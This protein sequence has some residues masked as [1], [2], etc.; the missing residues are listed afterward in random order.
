MTIKQQLIK[1]AKARLSGEEVACEK[2][3]WACLRFLDD[4]EKEK[5]KNTLSEPFLYHW[6]EIE[7]QKI[8]DWFALLKHHKGALAGEF[9]NL[10]IDQKFYVC[11]LYGWREDTNGYKRFTHSF[12]E[13]ARK[14]AKSQ[15][16]AGIA[17][18]EISVEATK[19]GEIYEAYTAGTK[20]EQS[21]I[22]FDEANNMLKGSPLRK[23]FNI[24]RN[25]ITHK[26]TGSYIKTLSKE[27]GKQGDGTNPALLILDE[28]HQHQ[29]TE[30][31]DLG[32][33]GNT[34]QALLMIITTAGIDLNCPC[35]QQEYSY[36]SDILNPDKPDIVNDA[37][38]VIIFEA[39]EGDDIS[40]RNTWIKANPIRMS[41][42]EGEK[43]IREAYEIAIAIPEKMTA[44]LT[45][46]LNI[47]VQAK[48]N[49]YMD[50]SKWNKCVT[51]IP[52]IDTKGRPVYIGFDMSAKI[53][54]TSVA[55]VIPY[56][57]TDGTVKYLCYSHSFIPNRDKLVERSMKD[58]APYD[59]WER[60]G[61]I[62]ITNSEIVDQN[63]VMEYVE[64]TVKK[65][66]WKV[67][68]LCFDP[69]N[70]SKLMIDL[71]DKGY[72]VEEVF[73][74]HKSLNEATA[75]FRE[76]V[77]EGN[78]VIMINPVLNYA[79][80]NA[81]IKQNNGLIKIDKDATRKRIDPVDA[82]LCA[83]KLAYYHE[84]ASYS[85]VDEWLDDV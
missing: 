32:L 15:L 74:S 69:A 78:T 68:C 67:E 58:K 41:Y 85:Y 75:G 26:K 51:D 56:Q 45:K 50:M 7:A 57:K 83:F 65:Y 46:I 81:V 13:V 73:Q 27:D 60:N 61:Y 31:Y 1:Y 53:D 39:D 80:A 22:V 55:F 33:G 59:A 8:V 64:K 38:L 14:N 21:K 63:V 29:T 42:A 44:F 3:K 20:R 17:L 72:T 2:L 6:D 5:I 52:P 16:E 35:Y 47:W 18:Y 37:Y 77:Y 19:W 25:A 71:S 28:Y 12:M 10:T 4:V 43:K 82:L 84:F 66:G 30:F 76:Q 70:A 34:K 24:T 54:L 9:I 36:V 79:M 48:L 23:K 62:T 11:Q 40:D 49:G